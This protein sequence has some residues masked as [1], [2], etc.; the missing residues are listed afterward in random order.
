MYC[1][2]LL[3]AS[4]LA[5]GQNSDPAGSY[6]AAAGEHSPVYTGKIPAPYPAH[7]VNH[8]YLESETF[9]AGVL[10]FGGVVYPGVRM[11]LDQ[12]RDRLLALPPGGFYEVILPPAQVN[13]ARLHGRHIFH[14]QPDSL[15]GS[16]PRGYYFLLHEGACRIIRR[17]ACQMRE[18]N[19]DGAVTGWFIF[20]DKYY[21]LKDGVWHS[22]RSKGSTLNVFSSHKKELSRFVAEHKPDF[23]RNAGAAITAVVQ[24]YER[25]K[26]GL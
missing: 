22:V 17:T 1:Y 6:L 8:P 16:P 21:I 11:R 5:F 3:L 12:Y 25:I 24:E 9:A 23:R 20:S 2:A 13:H 15:K 10:S 7:L 14:H 26:T 18:T 4:S 19:K